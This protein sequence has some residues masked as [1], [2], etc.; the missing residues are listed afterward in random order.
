MTETAPPDRA[1]LADLYARYGRLVLRRAG[2]IVGNEQLARDVCHDVFV[3]VLLH[4]PWN[5]PSPIGWLYVT[6]TNLCLN[7]IRSDRRQRAAIERLASPAA[8]VPSGEAAIMLRR[9]PVELQ[10]LAVLY[11]ID[12]MSQAEIATVLAVSQKTI[13]NRLQRLRALLEPAEP[14]PVRERGHLP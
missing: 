5:P 12:Q 9:I 13:S 1:W 14:A 3:Q 10:E 4:H 11:A 2:R 7:L 6:T 8:A